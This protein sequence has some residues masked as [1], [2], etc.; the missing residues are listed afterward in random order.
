M[1]TRSTS[2]SARKRPVAQPSY[3][4]LSYW[5][6]A[7]RSYRDLSSRLRKGFQDLLA[8]A[9]GS[10]SVGG[11][12]RV[13]GSEWSIATGASGVTTGSTGAT[14]TGAFTGGSGGV[15]IVRERIS[16]GRRTDTVGSAGRGSCTLAV[17]FGTWETGGCGERGGGTTTGAGV[18]ETTG[19]G[20]G[21]TT[22]AGAGETTGAGAGETTGA[23]VGE[24]TGA[25]VGETTGAGVGETIGAGAAVAGT[26]VLSVSPS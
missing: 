21:E 14:T 15:S 23:G 1:R 4:L 24:T 18:G 13:S 10:G 7:V 26:L 8:A 20:A 19:A 3:N 16:S 11:G 22:G 5:Q 17:A 9:G 12:M 6:E 25:G 2:M